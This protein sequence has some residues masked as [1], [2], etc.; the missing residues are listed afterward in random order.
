MFELSLSRQFIMKQ[1]ILLAIGILMLGCQVHQS[2]DG[3]YFPYH[4]GEPPQIQTKD[5]RELPDGYGHGSSTLK[6]WIELNIEKDKLEK[7]KKEIN[8][9][10]FSFK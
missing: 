10:L 5:Y 9:K 8:L 7:R 4:W 6:N 2:P 3:K 1:I